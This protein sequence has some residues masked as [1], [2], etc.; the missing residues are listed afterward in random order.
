MGLVQGLPFLK[1]SKKDMFLRLVVWRFGRTNEEFSVFGH[2][3]VGF[4]DK[5]AA[6]LLELAK[7][8]IAELGENI[9]LEASE[10]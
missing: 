2:G 1:S 9:D 7:E 10:N 6:T 4:G 5:S 8:K 3:V